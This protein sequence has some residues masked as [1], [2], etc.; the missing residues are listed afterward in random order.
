MLRK[1]RGERTERIN[2]QIARTEIAKMEDAFMEAAKVCWEIIH[3]DEVREL[4]DKKTGDVIG[5]EPAVTDRD[6]L[7][8]IET[9]V[10]S[11]KILF[12]VKLDAGVFQRK[13]GE[14]DVKQFS[15][16]IDLV[17]ATVQNEHIKPTDQLTGH[18]K[19][20]SVLSEQPE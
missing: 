10:R 8:A 12:D 18:P 3:N 2:N 17:K 11:M 20:D 15:V 1:I 7:V 4:H 14:I 6:K 13:L 19:D 9:L 5:V 16:F